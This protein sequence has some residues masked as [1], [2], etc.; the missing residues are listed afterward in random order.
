MA[1]ETVDYLFPP[2]MKSATSGSDVRMEPL[3]PTWSNPLE[4]SSFTHW[5][6]EK[7]ESLTEADLEAY[8]KNRKKA[9]EEKPKKK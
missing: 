4:Y 5:K 6:A 8:E 7:V 9:A 2:L 3:Q 1:T